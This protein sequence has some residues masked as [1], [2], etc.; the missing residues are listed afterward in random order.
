MKKVLS[1]ATILLSM[2]I[3]AFAQKNYNTAVGVQLGAPTGFHIK[4]YTSSTN[5]VE[6][7]IGGNLL[8]GR[9]YNYDR[10]YKD[11]SYSNSFYGQIHY[12]WNFKFLDIKEM[13]WYFGVGGFAGVAHRRY[14]SSGYYVNGKYYY[15]N[16]NYYEDKV[17]P[18]IGVSAIFGV[19]Y[20][21]KNYPF[22]FGASLEPGLSILPNVIF[23]ADIN[24]LFGV[25]ANYTLK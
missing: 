19:E 6:A 10:R 23:A 13:N 9:D 25:H 5:S 14:Y 22:S 11:Y 7:V 12:E 3:A 8:S 21:M 16:G 1:L 2:S 4:H 17:V 24:P 18:L 20:T 15:N